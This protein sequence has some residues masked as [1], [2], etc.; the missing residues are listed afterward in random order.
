MLVRNRTIISV[1]AMIFVVSF[2]TAGLCADVA[3][4]GTVNF[5]KILHNSAG[6]KAVKNQINEEGRRM[7]ADL[8]K[9]QKEIE[10]LRSVLG[11]DG[12]AGVM[13]EAAREDKQ[14]ELD[15]KI[16]EIKA[17]QKRYD[18]KLQDLQMRLLNSVRKDVLAII[19]DYGKKEGYTLLLDELNVLYTP[20][21][22]DVTDKIIQLY[23]ALP[24]KTK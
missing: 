17:L 10:Q 21:S 19:R 13:N 22:I 4:I 14:W 20:Q 24:A 8:E 15:R 5:E 9:L 3:K 2:A 12:S 23:N 11:K 6:G 16:V 7:R 18:R 1:M